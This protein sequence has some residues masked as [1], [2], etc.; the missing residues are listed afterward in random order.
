MN[1]QILKTIG[2]SFLIGFS[3]SYAISFAVCHLYLGSFV[4]FLVGVISSYTFYQKCYRK[5]KSDFKES[6]DALERLEDIIVTTKQERS[7]AKLMINSYS[8]Q[9]SQYERHLLNLLSSLKSNNTNS[10]CEQVDTQPAQP[11]NEWSKVTA[12]P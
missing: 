10:S 7:L 2:L 5:N 11:E 4:C 9:F 1:K 12:R 3:F 6:N 8:E